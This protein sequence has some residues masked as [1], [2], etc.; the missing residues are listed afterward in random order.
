LFYTVDR[1]A[2]TVVHEKLL[3]SALAGEYLS[4]SRVLE[5]PEAIEALE[6]TKQYASSDST[7]DIVSSEEK[8]SQTSEVET[9]TKERHSVARREKDLLYAPR[10]MQKRSKRGKK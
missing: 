1:G 4:I 6:A 3:L 5:A 9:P 2:G 8:E 7:S 10:K